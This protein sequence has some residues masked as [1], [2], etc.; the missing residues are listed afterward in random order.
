MKITNTNTMHNELEKLTI[1][2]AQLLA[3][4]GK[5]L[6]SKIVNVMRL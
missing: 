1:Q 5:K 4:S 2:A 6:S 3:Q